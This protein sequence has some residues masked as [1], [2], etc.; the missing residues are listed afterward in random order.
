MAGIW[1]DRFISWKTIRVLSEIVK[2]SWKKP[3]SYQNQALM[4][5]P[6]N[7]LDAWHPAV[8]GFHNV[9]VLK[10]CRCYHGEK[11]DLRLK[12]C[13]RKYFYTRC[14]RVKSCRDQEA[15]FL[16]ELLTE[17]EHET[18][19]ASSTLQGVFAQFEQQMCSGAP[20]CSN[21]E[22]QTRW[23]APASSPGAS[24]RVGPGEI[25]GLLVHWFLLKRQKGF[26]QPW[27]IFFLCSFRITCSENY[28][29]GCPCQSKW[30]LVKT[31]LFSWPK[32]SRMTDQRWTGEVIDS[33]EVN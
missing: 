26:S 8:I 25:G 14:L 10:I 7:E 27:W 13:W 16:R 5:K 2:K 28:S 11:A 21:G 30:K 22:W 9:L 24:T 29:P 3:L 15:K 19:N 4:L 33:N 6:P 20:A 12:R 18:V 1:I 32:R 31:V 17:W 23:G